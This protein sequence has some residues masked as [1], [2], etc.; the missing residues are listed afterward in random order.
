MATIPIRLQALATDQTVLKLPHPYKTEFAVRKA[1]N[2][3]TKLPVYNLVPK[4][5]PTRPLPFELH[6]DHL[7]FTDAI[8][9]KSSELP[10]DSNNGAWA[11]ARRAPCVTLY[12]DGVEVP[13]LKQAWLVVYAF[14]TMRPGMD[15]FRL[16]LDGNSAANLARQIKDVLLGIDHPIK[17]RQQQEPCAKT[18]ENTLLILRS[19]FW[20]G[21]GCPF[22]PRP[23][24]CPQESPSSLLPSTCLSSFPLAPFH[25]TSTIS[26]AGD[27][28][29]FDRCQQSWHPIR[30]AKPA[31]GSIIYSRWIP[32]LG[33]MFS[34][35]AL[36]PE[37]SEHVRLF[38][39]WQ[40]DPRVLQGWTETKTLDQHRRYLE[41]LHK[42][43][44]Q[45][46]V[47]AK[48][49]DSP[50]AYFELYWAK[51]NRL[52]GYIDAGDFDRGRHSFVGDVRFRGPLRVSAWWSSLM[53]YLFL[54]D[55]RTMY[56]VGEPRDT[57]STVLMYDFIHGFGLDRFIDLPSKRSAF[58][59][60]SRDR[61][62]QSF[63]LE[64]SEKVIGGTSIRV[65]QKL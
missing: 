1:S 59:R 39:E 41:A 57:H 36:D 32:Y 17:A 62:F 22:G 34:M 58:M 51:E 23:V 25:R 10:P 49:D 50:F 44:H 21:A 43:P 65:V 33:E 45:L 30:P 56:I 28:E 52:G 8:H 42:D 6:N 53:H 38:H 20:Q 31:P 12:W 16:E 63:P 29:D 19:T 60:C 40:S 9:L 14:F 5:F 27:P 64:D 7:V 35:V 2:A 48:W 24:W 47:L 46:T 54:D 61:F 13:T 4:P 55:P 37:D 15:S 11:R 18:K 3:S 26:L